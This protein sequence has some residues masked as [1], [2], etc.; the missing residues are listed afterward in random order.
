MFESPQKLSTS[1]LETRV[2]ALER[3]FDALKE[4]L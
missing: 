3:K 2:L 1:D 4:A